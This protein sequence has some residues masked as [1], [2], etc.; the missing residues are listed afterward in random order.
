MAELCKERPEE[1]DK[2]MP[3]LRNQHEPKDPQYDE[4][5]LPHFHNESIKYVVKD[6]N[7][8]FK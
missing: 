1:S 8:D 7:I 6:L 5:I 2:K 3:Q 4:L